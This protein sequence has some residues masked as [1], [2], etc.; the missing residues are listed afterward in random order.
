[1]RMRI[2]NN[3]MKNFS[4]RMHK[5]FA[6]AMQL[7]QSSYLYVYPFVLMP[8]FC[9]LFRLRP[10]FINVKVKPRV[11]F[12]CVMD[13]DG[14][15]RWVWVRRRLVKDNNKEK[16][17]FNYLFMIQFFFPFARLLNRLI[18]WSG[19]CFVCDTHVAVWCGCTCGKIYSTAFSFY[20]VNAH[21]STQRLGRCK[22]LAI[23][24]RSKCGNKF[25]QWRV[26]V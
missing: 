17:G 3:E 4:R 21:L 1:M 7:L 6:L 14:G 2:A 9:T 11:I 10:N 12:H 24:K 5:S 13:C 23:C 20:H 19:N 18:N 26:D 8:D 15:F 16:I 25:S 22:R